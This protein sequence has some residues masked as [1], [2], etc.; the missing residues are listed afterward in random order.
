[1]KSYFVLYLYEAIYFLLLPDEMF[2]LSALPY[3]VIDKLQ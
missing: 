3:A 2:Q 1:M